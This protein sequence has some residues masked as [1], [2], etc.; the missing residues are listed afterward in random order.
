MR[1]LS[2]TSGSIPKGTLGQYAAKVERHFAPPKADG[3]PDSV[4]NFMKLVA[5]IETRSQFRFPC[6]SDGCSYFCYYTTMLF[7]WDAKC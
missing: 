3:V 5:L 7:S 4:D 6:T 2:T 1:T